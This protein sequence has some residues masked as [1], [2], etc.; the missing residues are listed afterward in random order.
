MFENRYLDLRA[1]LRKK[2]NAYA[3]INGGSEYPRIQ[4]TVRFY[5]TH[6]GVIVAAEINGLPAPEAKCAS[7]IF[8][9]HIHGG[10]S[11]SG[12]E[13]DEF[14]NAGTHYNPNECP[15]PFHAGDLP[16]I[17]GNDGYALMLFLTNRFTVDEII[18]KTIIIHSSP[19]DFTTQPSG[20]AGTKIACG[21]IKAL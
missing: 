5:S 1:L 15:H 9:F 7:P 8:G 21:E 19:D 16:P 12:T 3:L 20:N 11:C 4:G 2:P 18:G 14:A 13:A 10:N 6:S 17:F